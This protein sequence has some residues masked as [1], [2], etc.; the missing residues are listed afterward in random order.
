VRTDPKDPALG[1]RADLLH[2]AGDLGV[3]MLDSLKKRRLVRQ[4]K[5][6]M[7]LTGEGKRF[8]KRA[9]IDAD[10]LASASSG[11]QALPRLEPAAASSPAR[12]VPPS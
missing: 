9:A 12:L 5:E 4:S 10:T 11:V 3:Q 1:R 8:G 6:T 2:L 7:E